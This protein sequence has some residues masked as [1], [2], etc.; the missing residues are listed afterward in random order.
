MVAIDVVVRVF[1]DVDKVV[2]V[3]MLTGMG[4]VMDAMT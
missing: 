2:T 3:C 4:I 1:V